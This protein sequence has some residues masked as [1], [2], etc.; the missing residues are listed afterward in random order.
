MLTNEIFGGIDVSQ[1]TLDYALR[2]TG[3]VGQ[4]RNDEVG[5]AALVALLKGSSPTLVVVEATGGLERPVVT[6]L[7]AAQIPVAVVNPR[8]ARAF[9]EAIGLLAKTDRVDAAGLAELGERLRPEARPLPDTAAQELA[10]LVTRRQ[11]LVAQHTAE[12]NRL[13]TAL[14]VVQE[15]LQQHLTWLEQAIAELETEIADRIE[16][17][18]QWRETAAIVDSAPGIGPHTASVLV[19]SL[20]ELGQLGGKQIAALVGVAPMARDS[21]K[22]HGPR[23]IK[24]GRSPVRTALYMATLAATRFNPVIKAFYQRLL[25]AGK[26]KK[27][28]LTACMRKLLTILNAM[29][30]HGTM[31]EDKLA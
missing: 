28:A 30:K 8:R 20:P 21:G 19:A 16:A 15:S 26:L 17:H 25:T 7:S 13:K 18:T 29:V 24:A 27:V 12:Q 1:A 10:A 22:K 6:A 4:V 5:I 2:P 11:Q 14:P 9:A 23:H 31:W 3:G